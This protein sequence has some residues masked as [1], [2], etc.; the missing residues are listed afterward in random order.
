MDAKDVARSL[1]L[2]GLANNPYA[3]SNFDR[4]F[5]VFMTVRKMITRYHNT[6]TINERLLINNVVLCL[7]AFGTYK[8]NRVFAAVLEEDQLPV[9]K[10]VLVFL[11]QLV[12]AE[13]AH[14]DSDRVMCDILRHV[15][16]RYN[17]SHL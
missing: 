5:N 6:G 8:V 10:S 14:V 17:L 1:A 2:Q 12:E 3:R 9:V 4:D 13:M 11:Q 15:S 7:N 16:N